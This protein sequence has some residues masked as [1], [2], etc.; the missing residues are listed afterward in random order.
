MIKNEYRIEQD[1]KSLTERKNRIDELMIKGIFDEETY[2]Q[3]SE[4]SRNEILVKQVELNETKIDLNDIEGCLNYCKYFLSN[5]A[6]LWANADVNLKQRF[7]T[8]LFP[9]KIYFE[10]GTFRTTEIA[11][12]FKQLQQKSFEESSL[13]APTGF[14]PVFKD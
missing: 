12:I 14:E 2:K 1:L 9:D 11:L 4:E 7:Q 10:N 5:L 8:L 6:K 13:V 3:K